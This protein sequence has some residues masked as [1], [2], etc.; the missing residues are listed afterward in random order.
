MKISKAKFLLVSLFVALS[1]GPLSLGAA[2]LASVG[3]KGNVRNHQ[4]S[5]AGPAPNS[6]LWQK[7]RRAGR[8]N[9]VP[10]RIRESNRRLKYTVKAVYPQIVGAGSSS[11][12][13]AGF[14]RAVRDLINGQTSDF[15]KD[16]ISPDE[17]I[18]METQESSFDA[19]YV[20]EH[21]GPDLISISFGISTYYAGAAHPNHHT[22]VLNYDL[23]AGR[24]LQ[25]SDLFKPRSNFLHTISDYTIKELKKKL[26]PDPDD[27][28]IT[29]GAAPD[30]EN[31]KSW[32]LTSRGLSVTFDPY[33]VA[34][35]A[36]GEHTVV[37]PYAALRGII[38]MNGPLGSVVK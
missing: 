31:Y 3:V 33:Q 7:S 8:L 2:A 37:I 1:F 19:S 32:N 15:K 26:G 9:F 24:A 38:D 23:N 20:I 16:F 30:S 29:R 18:S 6:L 5:S 13:A 21:R 35:Y 28:W 36:A 14:N 22:V 12:G 11:A 4:R 27:D 17:S 25:L 10:R 34:S